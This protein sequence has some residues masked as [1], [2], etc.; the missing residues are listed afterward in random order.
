[1]GRVHL[2]N[3]TSVNHYYSY[4]HHYYQSSVVLLLCL[5]EAICFLTRT[6]SEFLQ[7][8]Y[9]CYHC[10]HCHVF[11]GD[12]LHPLHLRNYYFRLNCLLFL[13]TATS[14]PKGPNSVR[15]AKRCFIHYSIMLSFNHLRYYL[16]N[17]T[18]ESYQIQHRKHKRSYCCYS[19]IK[20]KIVELV[21]E[22]DCYV[23]VVVD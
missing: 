4:S 12:H 16:W 3:L 2:V 19:M 22:V 1:M 8:S 9:V 20:L 7:L 21:D 14:N 18:G 10:D 15:L 23:E 5:G 6:P 11:D 17:R 13:Y